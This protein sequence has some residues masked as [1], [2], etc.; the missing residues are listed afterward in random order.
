[1]KKNS[2]FRIQNSKLTEDQVK[3]IAK[4]AELTLTSQ[5]VKKFQKQLSIVLEYIEVLD[6][7]DTQKIEPTSQVTGLENVF[8]EDEIKMTLSPEEALSQAKDKRKEMFKTKAV[9]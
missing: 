3:H 6:E 8:R 7:I 9:F 4:L 1:M 5:E 2:K